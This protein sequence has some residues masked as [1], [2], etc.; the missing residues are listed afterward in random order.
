MIIPIQEIVILVGICM[1]LGGVIWNMSKLHTQSV[2]NKESL[3]RAHKRV[4]KLEDTQNNKIEELSAQLKNVT[5]TQIRMEEK[6]NILLE[7]KRRE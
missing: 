2:Q 1:T 4:D 7:N 5:E 6:L 3:V